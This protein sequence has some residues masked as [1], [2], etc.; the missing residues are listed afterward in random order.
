MLCHIFIIPCVSSVLT[1]ISIPDTANDAPGAFLSVFLRL[2]VIGYGLFSCACRGLSAC[3]LGA[4]LG[5]W[6]LFSP[7]KTGLPITQMWLF[8]DAA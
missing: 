6:A 7:C 5:F 3:A 8:L 2:K 1:Q 4:F